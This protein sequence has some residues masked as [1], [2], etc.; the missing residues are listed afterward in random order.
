MIFLP[1]IVPFILLQIIAVNIVCIFIASLLPLCVC[2]Y[3]SSVCLSL[4]VMEARV[5]FFGVSSWRQA[6]YPGDIAPRLA[7]KPVYPED[8]APRLGGKPCYPRDITPRLGGKP[9]LPMETSP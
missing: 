5:Q 1:L 4:C 6:L 3:L 2:V 7:G 9:P 8:I